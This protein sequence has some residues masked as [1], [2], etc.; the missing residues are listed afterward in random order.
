MKKKKQ[1]DLKKKRRQERVRRQK[2]HEHV[3]LSRSLNDSAEPPDWEEELE[4]DTELDSVFAPPPFL[5]FATERMNRAIARLVQ[6]HNFETEEEVEDFLN[7]R[8]GLDWQAMTQDL[9]PD[10]IEEAQELAFQAME[11]EDPEEA[12]TLARRALEMDADCVD[13]RV[14]VAET[15][16]RSAEEAIDQIAL[17]VEAG[18]RV[19]GR[20][21]FE[22]QRGH[23]WGLVET[24]P[25]MRACAS[26]AHLLLVTGQVPE[27]IRH[28]EEMLELNPNDN[29]G[30]R[31][32]LL[33]AY[34][35]TDNLEGANRLFEEYGDSECALFAWGRVLERF[36]A[37]EPQAAKKALQKARRLNRHVEPYLAMRRPPPRSAPGYYSPGHETEAEYCVLELAFAWIAHPNAI[38]W[39]RELKGGV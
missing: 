15:T 6:Q 38:E 19:L 20:E 9:E 35:L 31:D 12:L 2:H 25:Y 23:F 18:E 14:V 33:G 8:M 22:E 29:Q 36:L 1:K 24:R 28:F 11:A 27:A 16:A 13:A 7:S 3:Q 26:L 10:P 30:V 37:G 39:L 34:L 4:E 17:A 5:R 21:F 32:S